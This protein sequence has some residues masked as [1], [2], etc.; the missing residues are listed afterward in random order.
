MWGADP[1]NWIMTQM[2]ASGYPA[3]K[4]PGL[5]ATLATKTFRSR[6]FDEVRAHVARMYCDHTLQLVNRRSD[7][8]TRTRRFECRSLTVAEVAYGADVLI[9]PGSFDQ[10][11]LVQIPTAGRAWV[12]VGDQQYACLPGL[13]SI[14]N[15]EQ[16]VEMFWGADCRKTVLRFERASFERFAEL[17]GGRPVRRALAMEPSL[18]MTGA[19][20]LALRS[21]LGSLAELAQAGHDDLPPLLLSHL[22]TCFMSAL[23]MCQARAGLDSFQQAD[24]HAPPQA[25]GKVRDYLHAHAHEPIDLAALCEV[26]GVPLR[27]LHHQFQRHFGLTPQ[28][29]LRDI[30]LDR[31]RAD[32]LRG[33]P[34]ASVTVV[35]LNWGFEHFGRFAAHYRQRFGETPRETL[36]RA[37]G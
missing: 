26:A 12:G 5:P 8:D 16:P 2:E 14:Q 24:R 30:R 7:L 36:H 32:L 33:D 21:I 35:A 28:Q 6:D 18:A 37:R 15:P 9:N 1:E 20:G 4:P 22:E 23:L 19:S 13:A 34:G 29:L 17:H 27:T 10:F 11:Y 3:G 25:V 31:A